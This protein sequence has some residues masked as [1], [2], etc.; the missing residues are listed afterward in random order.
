MDGAD[1]A[2]EKAGT[3]AKISYNLSLTTTSIA[4]CPRRA[5]GARL[6]GDDDE[7]GDGEA[8]VGEGEVALNGTILAGTLMVKA[9]REWDEL[10]ARPEKLER[11]LERVGIP[12]GEREGTGEGGGNRGGRKL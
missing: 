5:E 10:R 1:P 12:P 11:V 9:E 6:W 2:D 3:P 7:D 8:I 4:L